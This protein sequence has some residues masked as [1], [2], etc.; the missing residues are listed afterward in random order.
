MLARAPRSTSDLRQRLLR[1][2]EDPQQVEEV[3]A[4]LTAAGLLDDDAYARAFTRSKV[5]SQGFSRRRLQQELAKRGVE[6]VVASEAIDEVMRD[7]DVD[8]YASIERAA[9][10]KLRSLAALDDATRKRRLYAYLARR[11][12]APEDVRRVTRAL[13]AEP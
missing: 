6:R 8:E 7:D 2:G 3:I 4:R 13:L 9:R 12:Y 11:G 5:A 1:K 10:K